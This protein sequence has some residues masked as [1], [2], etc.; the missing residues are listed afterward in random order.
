VLPL[1][2]GDAQLDALII[3]ELTHLVVSEIIWPGRIGDGGVPH[4]VK[5]GIASHVLGVWL[6]EDERLMRELVASSEIPALSQLS[7][8]GGFANVRINDALGHAAF[9]Y[10]KSRWGPNSVRRFLNALIMPRVSKTYDAVFDLINA[11]RIRRRIPAVRRTPF[12][13][14]RSLT[15]LG[16]AA[17][18]NSRVVAQGLP[19]P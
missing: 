7:G 10:I 4:W 8:S 19:K 5:E 9:D 3:H 17:R 14:D 6:D 18:T 15:S 13:A 11:S 16:V 2:E 1:P 12:F